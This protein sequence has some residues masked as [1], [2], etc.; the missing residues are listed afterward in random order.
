MADP[1]AP[2]TVTPRSTTTRTSRNILRGTAFAAPAAPAQVLQA[3][4]HALHGLQVDALA[5]AVL[6]RVEQD[7][8]QRARGVRVLR[9]SNAGHLPPLLL[10]DGRARVLRTEPD[11][12]L[13]LLPDAS[14]SDAVVELQPGDVVLLHTDGLVERRGESLD[15]GVER[16][17]LLLEGLA[18]AGRSLDELCDALLARLLPGE[19]DDDVA[20]L[21]LQV[22]PQDRPRPLEA[23]PETLPPEATDLRPAAGDVGG[24]G[25]RSAPPAR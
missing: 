4:E 11:L 13:G 12:L 15:D 10:Q 23:S 7:D 17:R 24:A 8:D 18:P 19:A 5:T 16:L 3:L 9:W 22:H 6:A 25:V 21:A 14:R 1:S 20:L 2:S